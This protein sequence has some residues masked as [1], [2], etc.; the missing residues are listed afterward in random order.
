LE[1]S[2][3]CLAKQLIAAKLNIANGSDPA[4]ISSTVTHADSLLSGFTGK[5]PY[6]VKYTRSLERQAP[7][8]LE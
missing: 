1:K 5:L 8:L 2:S 4:P 3:Q 6:N 7:C